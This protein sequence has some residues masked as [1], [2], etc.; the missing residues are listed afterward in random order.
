MRSIR[1]LTVSARS[2]ARL[3]RDLK[4]HRITHDAVAAEANV[5]RTTVVHT[6]AGRMKSGPILRAAGRLLADAKVNGDAA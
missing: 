6:L 3:K 4:R 5:H 1:V 2:L